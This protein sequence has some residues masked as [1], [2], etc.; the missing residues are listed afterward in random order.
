MKK[1]YEYLN[2][3]NYELLDDANSEEEVYQTEAYPRKGRIG[4]IIRLILWGVITLYCIYSAITDIPSK[5]F[6]TACG[7]LMGPLLLIPV[8]WLC[9]R[10]S[11]LMLP[12]ARAITANLM[13][14]S[15]AGF[16]IKIILY[17]G[18]TLLPLPVIGSILT[19]TAAK[20]GE[21]NLLY[22]I[23]YI[24][25]LAIMTIVFVFWDISIVRGKG[26]VEAV[27]EIFDK[28]SG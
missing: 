9:I 4:A 14:L 25:V 3:E 26:L 16:F 8:L 20:V 24:A 15:L 19:A 6:A 17:M 10:L 5:G 23:L 11:G 1:N 22:S 21:D 28:I 18:V 12:I 7:I 2:D 13:P 27:K